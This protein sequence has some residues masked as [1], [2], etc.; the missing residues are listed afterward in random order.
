M[1]RGIEGS[2]VCIELFFVLLLGDAILSE[3]GNDLSPGS[4]V[5]E[6]LAP[7]LTE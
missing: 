7:G 4:E 2:L 5:V 1:G 6:V 3:G